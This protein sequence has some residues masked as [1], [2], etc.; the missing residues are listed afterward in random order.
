M[1]TLFASVLAALDTCG[2][3]RVAAFCGDTAEQIKAYCLS[4]GCSVC[5][6]FEG[7]EVSSANAAFRVREQS[8]KIVVYYACSM[9]RAADGT[10]LDDIEAIWGA[11]HGLRVGNSTLQAK[12][13][14][15]INRDAVL[16]FALNF[17]I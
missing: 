3:S 1:K 12:D 14:N 13:F 16:V 15:L 10:N 17:T 5:A 6:A 11:L 8:R 4:S 7:A 2:Y 9:A